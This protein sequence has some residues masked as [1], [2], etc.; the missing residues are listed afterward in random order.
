MGMIDRRTVLGGLAALACPAIAAASD[1]FPA[2]LVKIIVSQAPGSVGDTTC[3]ILANELKRIW[4]QPVV[5]ENRVG[6]SG[7]I[8]T[9]ALARSEPDGYTIG[10]INIASHAL[11]PFVYRDKLPY[12]PIKDFLPLSQT[13]YS[14]LSALIVNT[15]KLPA[16]DIP[17]LVERLRSHPGR[18]TYATLGV[19]TSQHICMELFQRATGTK[20]VVVPYNNLGQMLADLT[21]GVVDMIPDMGASFWTN[22]DNDKLRAL[23]VTTA[24]RSE[25][26]PD[27]PT[28]AETY[29]GLVISSWRG[30]A[31]PANV[32]PAI[33]ARLAADVHAALSANAVRDAM[34]KIFFVATPQRPAEFAAFIAAEQQRFRPIITEAGITR[35]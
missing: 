3:R 35:D 25:F 2:R 17:Q 1:G 19:G 29:P 28:L 6:A 15:S 13:G 16:R 30:L 18:Y 5:V 24:Q 31:T 10:E 34:R 14:A 9:A 11:N 8:G 21:S 23:A 32:P 7:N 33:H 27:L 26:A 20:V 12:D 22:V 4:G